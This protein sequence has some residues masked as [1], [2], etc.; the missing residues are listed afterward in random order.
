MKKGPMKMK[1]ASS[2][3]LIKKTKESKITS[4]GKKTTSRTLKNPITGNKRTVTFTEGPGTGVARGRRKKTV[5]TTRRGVVKEQ[6]K[7]SKDPRYKV[8]RNPLKK[9]LVGKQ[10]NLPAGLRQAILDSPAKMLKPA[11]MK[12]MKPTAMKMKKASAMT[13]KKKSAMTMKKKSA[14]A[15]K[16]KSAMKMRMKKK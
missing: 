11:A 12:M 3:K 1:K 15:M 8:K 16:K 9:A 6:I 7:A 2:M 14:M 10:K 4:R 13:M 5:Q